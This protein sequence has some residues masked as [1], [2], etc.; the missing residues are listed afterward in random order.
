MRCVEVRARSVGQDTL[1]RN[2]D[3]STRQKSSKKHVIRI[4]I[5]A[6]MGLETFFRNSLAWT[7]ECAEQACAIA[8]IEHRSNQ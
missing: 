1:H 8:A 5:G 4:F 3:S 2:R 7:L 6:N